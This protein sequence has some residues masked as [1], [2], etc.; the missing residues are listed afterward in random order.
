MTVQDEPDE[1]NRK[2]DPEEQV[3]LHQTK[4]NLVVREHRLHPAV[5]PE[6]LVDLPTELRID[7]VRKADISQLCDRDDDGYDD[8]KCMNGE[9]RRRGGDVS[10]FTNLDDGI[11]K[12]QG[13][14]DP[15]ELGKGSSAMKVLLVLTSRQ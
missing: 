6:K 13:V 9:T 12:E 5:C 1:L 14:E 15:E 10:D 7:L 8:G 11:Y 3:E 2:A 4:E